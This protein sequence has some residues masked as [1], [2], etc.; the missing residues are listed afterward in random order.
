[1]L[2]IQLI[3]RLD[4]Q[5]KSVLQISEECPPPG[6]VSVFQK[7]KS[8]LRLVSTILSQLGTY[9]PLNKNI[10]RA[11][12][13]TPLQDVKVVILGQ[14]PYHSTENGLPQANGLSFSTNRGCSIQPALRNIFQELAREYPQDE[15]GHKRFVPPS[16]G[17]LTKW[18][19]QGVLML[20]TCLTVMPHQAGSHKE[21]WN[22]FIT[23]VIEAINETNPQ[24]IYLLWGKKAIDF[25]S[26]RLGQGAIKLYASHPSPFSAHKATKDVPA[27]I[28]CNHFRLA[29]E[30][31]VKQGKNPIDWTLD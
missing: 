21:I 27:F 28:G 4:C 25:S 31:L 9:F 30:Y 3:E 13:L 11:F 10:F 29:N 5:D 23:R 14:D 6:W 19:D 12:D 7:S 1:M 8:E 22:G 15:P 17:D 24:C 16:H 26:H 20:N 2:S 18:A